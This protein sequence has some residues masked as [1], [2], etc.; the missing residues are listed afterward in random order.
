MSAYGCG[1]NRSMQHLISNDRE[2]DVENEAATKDL[3]HRRTKGVDVGSLEE[4]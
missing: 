3:L 1:F 2:E 4:R